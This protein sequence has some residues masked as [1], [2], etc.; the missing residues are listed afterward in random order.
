[1]ANEKDPS[2]L[3]LHLSSDRLTDPFDISVAHAICSLRNFGRLA[4]CLSRFYKLR[5]AGRVL[6][7]SDAQCQHE[8]V[9][10]ALR[11][12]LLLSLQVVELI[13]GSSAADCVVV[14][15]PPLR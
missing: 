11:L 10:H 8:E 9:P 1:M 2:A 14:V 15:F 12:L 6:S 5:G 4:R 7:P 13:N 3:A